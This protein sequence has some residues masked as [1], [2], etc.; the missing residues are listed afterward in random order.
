MSTNKTYKKW[1]L[2][3]LDTDTPWTEQQI[4]FFRMYLRA[5]DS[6]YPE[7]R[8]MFQDIGS[9]VGYDITQEHSD[10]GRD[11]LIRNSWYKNGLRIRKGNILGIR[12]KEVV[13]NLSHHKLVGLY[14]QFNPYSMG[15]SY[16]LPIYRAIARDGAIF[17]Y[18][19]TIYPLIEII[20]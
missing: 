14:Q 8:R 16:T 2:R 9:S 11:Y 17:E 7:L 6:K 4:I 20:G 3:V 1:L 19:G 13:R 15:N 5:N 10:K 18:T 12:E